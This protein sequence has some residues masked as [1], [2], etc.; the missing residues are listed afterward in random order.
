MIKKITFGIITLFL[1]SC[2][3]DHT[4]FS[5]DWIDKTNE[6][7]RMVIKKNGDNYIVENRDKKYP[8]QIKEGLLEIST[9]L[10]LKATIDENDI[11]I[12]NGSEY[13]RI[14]KATKPKLIGQWKNDSEYSSCTL[15]IEISKN[16][17][18]KIKPQNNADCD[19]NGVG[20]RIRKESYN[21]GEI[22]Y[23]E[24]QA[25]MD[26]GYY[27]AVEKTIQLLDDD[28]IQLSNGGPHPEIYKKIGK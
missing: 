14:E 3:V 19:P 18:V 15:S 25:H 13:I 11:L 1:V 12:I 5:G 16:D 9:E 20:I 6:S 7:D 2:G 8:A 4:D 22:K 28:K 10:P 27:P 17:R 24:Q 21:N 26:G 23:Q